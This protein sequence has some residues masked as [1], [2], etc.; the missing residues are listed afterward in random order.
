MKKMKRMLKGIISLAI[1]LSI[2]VLPVNAAE[3]PYTV[4]NTN[5]GS[6]D[7]MILNCYTSGAVVSG[8]Q[9]STWTNTGNV[10]Q[11]WYIFRESTGKSSLRPAANT[12]LALNANRSAIGTTANVLTAATN[13]PQD[14]QFASRLHVGSF[15]LSLYA[16]YAHTNT[17]Y[18]TSHGAKTMCTWQYYNANTDWQAY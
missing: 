9:V 6:G 14:Y 12:T 5:W 16:R 15:K 10:S 11:R 1:V 4:R 18:L 13:N 2:C 3:G 17:V 7:G 8:T